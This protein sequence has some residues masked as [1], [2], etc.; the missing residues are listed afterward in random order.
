MNEP[1]IEAYA[2]LA[3]G[4]YLEGL[5]VDHA[6]GVTWYSDVL[7]GGVHGVTCEG[8]AIGSLNPARMWTGGVLMNYDGKVLSSGQHGIMWNDPATGASGWLIDSIDGAPINGVNE[9]VPD[10]EGGIV[11]GTSDMDAIIAGTPPQPVGLYRLTQAGAVILL[12]EGIGFTNGLAYDAA[13]R[14]LYC[15]DTFHATLAFDVGD[16]WALTNQRVF[17]EKEDCDG[18]ALD[19]AGNLWITGFRSRFLER[20]APDGTVLPRLAT[21]E[22]SITQVRFGGADLRDFYLTVVPADGG[23]TLKEG[24]VITEAN[25]HVYRGRSDMPGQAIGTAGFDLG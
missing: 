24:G 16:G 17:F 22:G 14:R 19:S 3:S 10:G 6:R 20:V 1:A 5:A 23:D 12:A 2:K 4:L 9:M 8:V 15:N 25:S 18:M 13:R 21:P 11:F 7:A